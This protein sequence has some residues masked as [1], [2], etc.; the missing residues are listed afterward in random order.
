V[1][2]ESKPV[3]TLSTHTHSFM[4]PHLQ[5]AFQVGCSSHTSAADAPSVVMDHTV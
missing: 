2:V 5:A 1:T 3:A 4:S